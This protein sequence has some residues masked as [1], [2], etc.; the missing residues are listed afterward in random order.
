MKV[1]AQVDPA[2]GRVDSPT[3]A[4]VIAVADVFELG[5]QVLALANAPAGANIKRGITVQ[6]SVHRRRSSRSQHTI[7]YLREVFTCSQKDAATHQ[8]SRH[9]PVIEEVGDVAAGAGG[10]YPAVGKIQAR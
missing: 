2:A 9:C 8:A 10:P 6:P 5:R 3:D 7:L 4:T 1:V